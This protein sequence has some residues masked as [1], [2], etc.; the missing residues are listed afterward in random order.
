LP[1]SEN[2]T[3]TVQRTFGSAYTAEI[4]YIGTRGIHLP[5]QDQINIQQKVTPTNVLPTVMGSTTLEAAGSGA[6]TLS[7]ITTL[8]N[9]V[10]AWHFPADNYGGFTAKVTSYQPYSESNYNAFIANLTRRLQKGFQ[11]NLSYTWSKTMD[12]ATD[13][14]F[15][16]VLTPRRQQNH[17]CIACDYSRSALDRTHRISLEVVYDVPFYKTSSNFLMK[18]LVGN[19]VI[20]P[21]YT[22]ESPEYATVLSGV[23]SV[24]N[25]DTAQAIDRPLVNPSG[26]KGTATGTVAIVNPSLVS[27]CDPTATSGPS[28]ITGKAAANGVYSVCAYDVTGYSAGTLSGTAFTPVTNAY[29]VEANTGTQPTAARN[30]LP[31]RPIDNIDLSLFKRL[32]VREHYSLEVGI[33]TWNILNHAQYQPGTVDNVNGPSYTAAYSFQTVSSS[34][35]NHPE[36]EFLNNPRTMQISGKIIF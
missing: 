15:A 7:A 9:I 17:Q 31:I 22:Y 10:P 27:K 28:Q 2:Y 30:T 21:V 1:Y 24:Q 25:G 6:T 3:L 12:D 16:T 13:E 35:F 14:V 8:S 36:K 18:N 34:S 32:T 4:G 23:N 26:V 5:T 11:M 20:A 29:Y 33:Q 19:W